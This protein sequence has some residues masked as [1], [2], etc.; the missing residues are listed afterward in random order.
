MQTYN[1]APLVLVRDCSYEL[2]NFALM[3]EKK[4]PEKK[5]R[6]PG[7]GGKRK[8]SGRDSIV[9]TLPNELKT[10]QGKA[11]LYPSQEKA[12]LD[13]YGSFQRFVDENSKGLMGN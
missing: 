8:G 7:S 10:K 2:Y 12:I 4:V 9:L 11:R 5:E 3:A 1:V 13:K 6:K